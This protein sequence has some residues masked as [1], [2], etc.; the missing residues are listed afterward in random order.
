MED[1]IEHKIPPFLPISIAFI[2]DRRLKRLNKDLPNCQG[3]GIVFSIF[4]ELIKEK[5]MISINIV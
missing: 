3:I 1:K 2:G 5:K 4:L